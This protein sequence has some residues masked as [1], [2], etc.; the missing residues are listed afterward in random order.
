M[1]FTRIVEGL[2]RGADIALEVLENKAK[3]LD[4]RLEKVKSDKKQKKDASY[5]CLERDTATEK[6]LDNIFQAD[7][8]MLK[9]LPEWL[10]ND[11]I[12][13]KK[14]ENRYLTILFESD[15]EKN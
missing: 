4:R 12:E 8:N 6:L 13:Y 5:A 9:E 14:A 2:G 3:K 11:A 10:R 15:E 7:E 1:K